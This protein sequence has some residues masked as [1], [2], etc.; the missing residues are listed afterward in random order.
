MDVGG[1]DM[2]ALNLRVSFLQ[3]R[4]VTLTLKPKRKQM[5]GVHTY[6]V[7]TIQVV[8]C[9]TNA[10]ALVIQKLNYFG[11]YQVHKSA[12]YWTGLKFPE[13]DHGNS[14]LPKSLDHANCQFPGCATMNSSCACPSQLITSNKFSAN[15]PQK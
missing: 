13:N 12:I 1:R 6:L 3:S 9:I 11:L 8:D 10:S 5:L 4:R 14:N 7:F 15:R 2:Y